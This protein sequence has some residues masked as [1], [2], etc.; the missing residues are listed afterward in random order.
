MQ[1]HSQV[2]FSRKQAKATGYTV[3]L[4]FIHLSYCDLLQHTVS[5]FAFWNLIKIVFALVLNNHICSSLSISRRQRRAKTR[6]PLVP[7]SRSLGDFSLEHS[8]RESA[9]PSPFLAFLYFKFPE[10]RHYW[11]GLSPMSTPQSIRFG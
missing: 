9:V 7:N 5:T 10:K 11:P 6:V 1:S 8:H 3:K 4:V 2:L